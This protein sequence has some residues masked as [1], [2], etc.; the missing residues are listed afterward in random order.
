MANWDP[1][2][3]TPTLATSPSA[4]SGIGPSLAAGNVEA[5]HGV[6]GIV[7]IAV[8][9]LVLLHLAGFRFSVAVGKRS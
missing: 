8:A 1:Q 5:H 2:L 6:I 3:L 7:L 4:G 9:A